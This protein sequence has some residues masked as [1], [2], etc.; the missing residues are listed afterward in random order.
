M[1]HI[2]KKRK[3]TQFLVN[4]PSLPWWLRCSKEFNCNVADLGWIP[5]LGRSHGGGHGNPRQHSCLE[6]PTARGAW[7]AAV[8]GVATSWT[9]LST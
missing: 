8:R 7:Q 5:G 2:K 1:V 3:A 9:P 4:I 6:N